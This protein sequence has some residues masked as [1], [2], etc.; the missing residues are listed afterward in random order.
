MEK[1]MN[2]KK[3]SIHIVNA[4]MN[5]FTASLIDPNASQDPKE[6]DKMKNSVMRLL[7]EASNN[8]DFAIQEALRPEKKIILPEINMNKFDKKN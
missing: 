2:T 7:A 3:I 5:V 8:I 4:M 1:K 6:Q